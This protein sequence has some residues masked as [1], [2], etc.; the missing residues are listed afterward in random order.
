MSARQISRVPREPQTGDKEKTATC[1]C[2]R[3]LHT[4]RIAVYRSDR[5]VSAVH[6]NRKSTR[7]LSPMGVTPLL[8]GF[9]AA[10][11]DPVRKVKSSAKPWYLCRNPTP[12]TFQSTS[13]SI[14][15]AVTDSDC[16]GC[17][18]R[19]TNGGLRMRNF[20]FIVPFCLYSYNI[21]VQMACEPIITSNFSGQ[22]FGPEQPLPCCGRVYIYSY[23]PQ[24]MIVLPF[25]VT[26]F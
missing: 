13:P 26:A 21:I 2:R 23:R 18:T 22:G 20:L 19:V 6:P 1:P 12:D 14:G 9:P 15:V 7:M 25:Y 16:R 10:V 17:S 5:G 24:S 8:C 3:I 4:R 11:K